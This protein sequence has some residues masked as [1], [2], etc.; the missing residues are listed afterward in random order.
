MTFNVLLLSYIF[1]IV[2]DCG[3]TFDLCLQTV[4]APTNFSHT[5][6]ISVLVAVVFFC[7][8]G[9]TVTGLQYW[10]LCKILLF[11]AVYDLTTHT[12]PDYVHVLLLLVG[13]IQ[14]PDPLAATAGFLLLP[15][16]L[17][18]G[19]MLSP[20]SVGGADIKLMAAVGPTLGVCRGVGGM[21]VGLLLA[22]LCNASYSKR[23]KPFP[24][25]PYLS[26]GC[27]LAL[28]A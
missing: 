24:L 25:V 14:I 20:G 4:S 12:V 19:A 3:Y 28:L 1:L 2:L 16:P 13:L 18:L 26:L 8:Y 27:F 17:L 10:L 7:V 22:I 23:K 15:L 9:L 5:T 11:A 6:A 21:M